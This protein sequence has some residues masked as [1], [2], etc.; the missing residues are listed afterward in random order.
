MSP[1]G[2]SCNAPV[3]QDCNLSCGIMSRVY[4]PASKH[5]NVRAGGDDCA[6]CRFNGLSW[7]SL[8]SH[9]ITTHQSYPGSVRH[10]SVIFHAVE[11]RLR[12]CRSPFIAWVDL[13]SGCSPCILPTG[14]PAVDGRVLDLTQHQQ[15]LR[16]HRHVI[17]DIHFSLR[18]GCYWCNSLEMTRIHRMNGSRV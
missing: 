14:S 16:K 10:V 7:D 9:C 11:L 18:A 4:R 13:K 15:T 5:W 2:L 1:D 17:S 3:E 6:A 8:F 12:A